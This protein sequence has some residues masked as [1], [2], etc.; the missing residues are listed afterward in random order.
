MISAARGSGSIVAV[1]R[2]HRRY[3]H[4][5][6]P[7]EPHGASTDSLPAAVWLLWAV[8]PERVNTGDDPWAER[9]RRPRHS[10]EPRLIPR[11]TPRPRDRTDSAARHS[12]R[13]PPRNYG[14]LRRRFQIL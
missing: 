6:V 9:I 8:E 7:S 3:A 11:R 14:G 1:P 10:P 12:R 4:I 13:V 5:R 2:S